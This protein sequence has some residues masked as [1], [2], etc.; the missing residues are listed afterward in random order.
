MRGGA[1]VNTQARAEQSC[2][3]WH[4]PTGKQEREAKSAATGMMHF[5]LGQRRR[6]R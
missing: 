3:F 6:F 4:K 5:A 1:T 2:L